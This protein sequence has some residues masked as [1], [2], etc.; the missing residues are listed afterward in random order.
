MNKPNFLPL[1][2]YKKFS[3]EE[4]VT[5]SIDFYEDTKR[6]RTVREFSSETVPKEVIENCI[7][8]AGTAPSGAPA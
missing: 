3:K 5:R 1:T 8:A 7:L 4:T 6:R 2:S